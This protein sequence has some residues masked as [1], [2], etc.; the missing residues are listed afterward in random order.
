MS[1]C[2]ETACYLPNDN[3]SRW[4]PASQSLDES[5]TGGDL[6]GLRFA[7]SFIGNSLE[8]PGWSAGEILIA[9]TSTERAVT[10]MRSAAWQHVCRQCQK[11]LTTV[12]AK[13]ASVY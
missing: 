4:Q 11:A 1:V 3:I 6:T 7:K 10:T 9:V 8:M 2:Y 13:A 5:L 12:N